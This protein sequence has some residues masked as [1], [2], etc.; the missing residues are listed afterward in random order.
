M[1]IDETQENRRPIRSRGVF[2]A[3]VGDSP[4]DT[5]PLCTCRNVQ[6]QREH[7]LQIGLIGIADRAQSFDGPFIDRYWIISM[8]HSSP[9]GFA[10]PGRLR[11][12]GGAVSDGRFEAA[13]FGRGLCLSR[14]KTVTML[15]QLASRGV[16][17]ICFHEHWTDIQN[18]TS[19]THEKDLESLVAACHEHGIQL[20]LYFGYLMS[21]IAPEWSKYHEQCL[22]CR[23]PGITSASPSRPPTWSATRASGRTSWPTG[24]TK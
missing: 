22:A 21:D 14:G 16:R 17:T 12:P 5:I 18:Y 19:T 23:G 4:F 15:D 7:S 24:S 20:L 6:I 3:D 13:R 8:R 10:R 11:V 9:T 2:S 1:T